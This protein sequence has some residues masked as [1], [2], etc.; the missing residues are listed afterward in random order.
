MN[1]L[2]VAGISDHIENSVHNLGDHVIQP[3]KSFVR[4][5]FVK[6]QVQLGQFFCGEGLLLDLPAFAGIDQHRQ[7]VIVFDAQVA[8]D[9]QPV[10]SRHDLIEAEVAQRTVCG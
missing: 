9:D 5:P 6:L 8:I 4:I 10:D 2:A 7:A 1:V 3:F